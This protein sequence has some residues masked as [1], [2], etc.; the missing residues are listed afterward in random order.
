MS[1]DWANVDDTQL[2]MRMQGDGDVAHEACIEL[3]LRYFNDLVGRLERMSPNS[4]LQ[5]R[6]EVVQQVFEE[7]YELRD[8]DPT[9]ESVLSRLVHPAQ[10]KLVKSLQ[11]SRDDA[12]SSLG[13]FNLCESQSGEKSS[14]LFTHMWASEQ[15]G[16]MHEAIQYLPEQQRM[17]TE[18]VCFGGYDFDKVA[19]LLNSPVETVRNSFK[20]ALSSIE[21]VLENMLNDFECRD[22]DHAMGSGCE[23]YQDMMIDMLFNTSEHIKRS[24]DF[25]IHSYSCEYCQQSL[26][27]KQHLV[28]LLKRFGKYSDDTISLLESQHE[29]IPG[30]LRRCHNS[31]DQQ[32]EQISIED[33]HQS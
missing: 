18:L 21:P 7:L 27:H 15:E 10:E 31:N 2:L 14:E 20:A 23:I 32:A 33:I 25:Y 8:Y 6:K 17:V 9:E 29:L 5:I 12:R 16:V 28:E 30:Y 24:G 13:L 11:D 1:K 22:S 3:Y 19:L 26:R 4:P